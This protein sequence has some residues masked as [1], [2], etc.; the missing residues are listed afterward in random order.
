[1]QTA[2]PSFPKQ[3][4]KVHAHEVS[5]TMYN[6][7]NDPWTK[8]ALTRHEIRYQKMKK[9]S[10]F[11]LHRVKSIHPSLSWFQTSL[12]RDGWKQSKN[13]QFPTLK[14]KN[15]QTDE[16]CD[17]LFLSRCNSKL[18]MNEQISPSR[19][20]TVPMLVLN[21]SIFKSISRRANSLRCRCPQFRHWWRRGCKWPRL[22]L[23]PLG[24]NLQH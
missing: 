9:K 16:Q 3:L 10:K 19:T 12:R 1:M 2:N 14:T 20:R 11:S 18:Q 15:K 17:A 6:I 21:G 13:Q 7:D 22:D 24:A 4:T 23:T 8:K 5:F